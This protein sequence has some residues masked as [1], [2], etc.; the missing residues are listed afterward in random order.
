MVQGHLNEVRRAHPKS[1]KKPHRNKKNHKKRHQEIQLNSQRNPNK[2]TEKIKKI[3]EKPK[4]IGCMVQ[5][6]P[7]ELRRAHPESTLVLR[8]QLLTKHF[9]T[10]S[11]NANGKP[12]QIISHNY[13]LRQKQNEL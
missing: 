13:S 9:S 10:Q 5:G 6:H 11:H 2:F 1:N 12:D 3:T 7:N 8:R 4:T